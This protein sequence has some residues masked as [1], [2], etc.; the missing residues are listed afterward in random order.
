[1]V[2]GQNQTVRADDKARSRAAALGFFLGSDKREN[3]EAETLENFCLAF[4]H[5]PEGVGAFNLA[6][7]AHGGNVHH[8]LAVLFHEADKVR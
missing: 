1:M 6:G 3:R 4:V 2:I 7:F 5:F 8:A